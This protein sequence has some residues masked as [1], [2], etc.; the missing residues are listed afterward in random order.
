MFYDLAKSLGFFLTLP[1]AVVLL[2]ILAALLLLTP[3][4]RVARVAV[5]ASVSLLAVC[6]LSP[7]GSIAL[8]PLE[9]RFPQPKLSE[10]PTGLIVLGGM[11]DE[12][13]SV[14][15]DT[16]VLSDAAERLTEA[17]ALSIRYP[18][19]RLVFSGGTGNPGGSAATESDSARRFWTEMGVPADRMSFENRSR[20]TWENGV[21]TKTLVDP[22]PGERWLL[23][24]SASH[25]PRSVGIFRRVGFPI[26]P[27]PVDYHTAGNGSDFKGLRNAA[28]GFNLL[29][30]ASHE[31]I[32]LVA[33]YL[34]DKTSALFPAPDPSVVAR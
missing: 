10:A 31:W 15:R 9:Q 1:N 17:V 30:T 21:F 23:V 14:I 34:A 29:S 24:T 13:L 33:Y 12:T 8:Q 18:A 7:L 28:D 19:M 22:K 6:A 26:I 32:G 16:V 25:M 2:V 3:F 27:Y 11:T 5:L 4:R 20:N